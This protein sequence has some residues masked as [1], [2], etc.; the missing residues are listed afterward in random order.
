MCIRD[1]TKP[2][3]THKAQH[4]QEVLPHH[5]QHPVGHFHSLSARLP[6]SAK[7]LQP[8]L[9][10]QHLPLQTSYFLQNCFINLEQ[11]AYN[12]NECSTH[13]NAC[14]TCYL[15][16]TLRVS[17]RYEV[18]DEVAII[19]FLKTPGSTTLPCWCYHGPKRLLSAIFSQNCKIFIADAFL[20]HILGTAGMWTDTLR[21]KS[22]WKCW[23]CDI[24][25]SVFK[26]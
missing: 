8:L 14:Y 5:T 18:I 7:G 6:C 4:V 17:A 12:C 26:W 1:R 3:L 11:R 25:S 19:H 9:L 20:Y 2:S 23:K 15:T 22:Q 16:I 24:R 10:C 21:P 13:R